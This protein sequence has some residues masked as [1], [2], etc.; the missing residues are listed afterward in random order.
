MFVWFY[1]IYYARAEKKTKREKKQTNKKKERTRETDVSDSIV[2]IGSSF[3]FPL[4][5][6]YIFV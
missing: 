3:V 1:M 6:V 2:D 4:T 5:I